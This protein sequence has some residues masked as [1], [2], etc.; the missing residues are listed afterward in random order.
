VLE[1]AISAP[2]G[3][4]APLAEA[5]LSIMIASEPDAPIITSFSDIANAETAVVELRRHRPDATIAMT[6]GVDEGP[7]DARQ[8]QIGRMLQSAAKGTMIAS[9]EAAMSLKARNPKMWI[10]PLGELPD[11]GGAISLYA[12]A[13]TA[14][15]DVRMD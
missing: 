8:A 3:T 13:I 11:V 5:A 4:Q 10:E 2:I 7:P 14:N 6:L 1:L 15:N 9:A 12:I